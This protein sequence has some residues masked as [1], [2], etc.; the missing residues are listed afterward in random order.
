MSPEDPNFP[1]EEYNLLLGSTAP[2]TAWRLHDRPTASKSSMDIA[3]ADIMCDARPSG[4]VLPK[5]LRQKL[6]ILNKSKSKA[7]DQTKDNS[8]EVVEGEKESEAAKKHVEQSLRAL[9][10]MARVP[11]F[12][13]VSHYDAKRLHSKS[14]IAQTVSN[15]EQE[16]ENMKDDLRLFLPKNY[17][18]PGSYKN[19]DRTRV[20]STTELEK[21]I[22]KAH[23]RLVDIHKQ[24]HRGEEIYF[25]DT[26]V[27]GN[28]Y[29]GWEAFI[30]SKPEHIGIQ[31][32]D[33]FPYDEINAL[34]P[35]TTS[36]A[37]SRKMHA[38]SRW[39]S[40]SSYSV[41]NGSIRKFDQR[42]KVSSKKVSASSSKVSS[43]STPYRLSSVGTR[44]S[45]VPSSSH[46]VYIDQTLSTSQAQTRSE[47]G[48]Q[49]TRTAETAY[50]P[51]FRAPGSASAS[52]SASIQ[53]EI[54]KPNPA[55]SSELIDEKSKREALPLQSATSERTMKDPTSNSEMQSEEISKPFKSDETSAK[56]I[57]NESENSNK[58]ID[59]KK[60]QQS[61]E[62]GNV[63]RSKDKETK[64][65]HSDKGNDGD[66]KIVGGEA[67]SDSTSG[68]KRNRDDL[69]D[70]S[71]K[72]GNGSDAEEDLR[73]S[74]RLR[75]KRK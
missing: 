34:A 49:S 10:D 16:V 9:E 62:S 68:R 73:S 19:I 42:K 54:P 61:E 12:D 4:V 60:A 58:N 53:S 8:K 69:E 65:V 2:G 47:I 59:S 15:Y 6:Q 7:S 1:H 50:V 64:P 56:K 66:G 24:L 45:P 41:E 13:R 63:E 52:V 18:T 22:S 40:S 31:H 75:K 57:E 71:G 28:I 33:R 37:P 20:F 74:S 14:P 11:L 17:E 23:A 21:K 72:G 5:I 38:D 70:P 26:D 27:H 43:P 3:L 67:A 39:F 29:K 30:D 55:P 25:Q 44:A 51:P 36:S 35:S 48:R 32:A 46:I